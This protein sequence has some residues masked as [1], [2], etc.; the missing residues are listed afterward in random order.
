MRSTPDIGLA[1]PTL[2]IQRIDV[3]FEST[4]GRDS[5]V[6]RAASP[7]SRLRPNLPSPHDRSPEGLPLSDRFCS[8]RGRF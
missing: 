8:S 3:L 4:I 5:R 6:N 1:G 2:G 7:D